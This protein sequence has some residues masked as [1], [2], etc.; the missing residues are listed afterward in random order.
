[1]LDT[2]LQL[3]KYRYV[4]LW[5]YFSL[6]KILWTCLSLRSTI[7]VG[8]VIV[9]WKPFIC[10]CWDMEMFFKIAVLKNFANFA[11]KHLCWVAF[12]RA[13]CQK[14]C[15]FIKKRSQHRCF[16]VKFTKFIRTLIYRILP[17]AVSLHKIFCKNIA[18]KARWFTETVISCETPP[19]L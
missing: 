3:A 11:G 14:A 19:K 13:A 9:T 4:I 12:N 1:M 5:A 6:L 15:N 10:E 8:W 18:R 7:K 2:S 16:P 17:V